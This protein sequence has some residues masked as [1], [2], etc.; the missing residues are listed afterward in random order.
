MAATLH[1]PDC[2][3]DD[4]IPYP[5]LGPEWYKCNECLSK[6]DNPVIIDDSL[7]QE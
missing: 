3:S 1:C 2:W 4:I 5:K 6:F 7:K